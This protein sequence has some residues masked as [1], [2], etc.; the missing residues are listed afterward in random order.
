MGVVESEG[1]YGFS[2][3]QQDSELGPNLEG[4]APP[5]GRCLWER[6]LSTATGAAP[7]TLA[8]ARL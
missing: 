6:L 2:L 3:P 5:G 1:L 8:P 4:A 7:G